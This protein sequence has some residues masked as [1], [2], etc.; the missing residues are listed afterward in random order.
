[1]EGS[2]R[3]DFQLKTKHGLKQKNCIWLNDHF[4]KNAFF[5]IHHGP[6]WISWRSLAQILRYWG[7]YETLW[8]W[9]YMF[10]SRFLF[11][12]YLGSLR[13]QRNGFEII[14]YVCEKTTVYWRSTHGAEHISQCAS[15]T[16]FV[17]LVLTRIQEGRGYL[18][19]PFR[20]IR[21]YLPEP[22]RQIKT[23]FPEPLA[24][25][26]FDQRH[27]FFIQKVTARDVSFLVGGGKVWYFFPYQIAPPPLSKVLWIR[28]VCLGGQKVHICWYDF[29]R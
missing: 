10:Q 27:G 22:F 23:Y 13:L 2:A 8:T 14:F 6:S 26:I 24:Y 20:Q 16:T 19:E 25:S 29:G 11:C 18:L 17:V 3:P 9:I 4:K 7:H 15:N 5:S 28:V 12:K 21:T 1:M